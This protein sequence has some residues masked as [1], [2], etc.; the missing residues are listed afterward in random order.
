MDLKYERRFELRKMILSYSKRVKSHVSL[1]SLKYLTTGQMINV[2]NQLS[3]DLVKRLS[4]G[5][6]DFRLETYQR[7]CGSRII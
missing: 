2:L 5:E 7:R 6:E 3:K 1:E 4:A